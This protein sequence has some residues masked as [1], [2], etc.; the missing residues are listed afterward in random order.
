M[1]VFIIPV[2]CLSFIGCSAKKVA[3][4]TALGAVGAGVGYAHNHED[5][6]AVVGGLAGAATGAAIGTIEEHSDKKNRKKGYDEGYKQAQVD[7]AKDH[8][9]HNT[10]KK[11]Y[12]HIAPKRF[13][14]VKIPK[15]ENNG[16]VYESRTVVLEDYR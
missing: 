2:L 6:D 3:Y 1:T 12:H 16:V 13:V 10:G 4:T 9:N 14:E 11:S 15:Q 5:R 7:I 8:W